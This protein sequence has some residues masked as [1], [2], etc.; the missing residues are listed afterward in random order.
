[1]DIIYIFIMN[2]I[3][4]KKIYVNYK[5]EKCGISFGNRKDYYNR[6]INRKK[7]CVKT[8]Q[9]N[10][11][12]AQ[13]NNINTQVIQEQQL[14]LPLKEVEKIND[15]NNDNTSNNKLKNIFQCKFCNKIFSRKFNLERHQNDSCKKLSETNCDGENNDVDENNIDENNITDE[16]NINKNNI[17]TAEILNEIINKY[18]TKINKYETTINEIISKLTTLEDKNTKLNK[19]YLQ[20]K[21][22]IFKDNIAAQQ[23]NINSVN[24]NINNV[25]NLNQSNININ[26]VNVVNFDNLNYNKLDQKLFTGPLL[27]NA[28]YGKAIILKLI[29]NI[30]INKDLPEYHN[31]VV[32]DKN[33]GYVKIYNNGKWNTDDMSIIDTVLDGII[34][35]SKYILEELNDIHINNNKIKNRL[36]TSEKYINFCDLEYL[37]E[38][39]EID[40]KDIIKRCKDFREMVHKDTI[41][42]FHDNK[43][44]I[45]KAKKDI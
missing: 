39:D 41:N 40:D 10:I 21:K 4:N 19:N 7:P 13:N 15:E 43:N 37:D 42:L 29:E 30:H 12:I 1:M 9:D 38:L 34:E 25:E 18:E 31:V 2:N 3:Y 35:H 5:C 44:I 16:T 33:R 45:L 28:L 23:T 11:T 36:G 14:K 24:N 6:H 20:L 22:K 8:A 26:I 27:D 32:T 17:Y